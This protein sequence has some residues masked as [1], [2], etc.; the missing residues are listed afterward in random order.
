MKAVKNISDSSKWNTLTKISFR[1][2]VIFFFLHIFPFPLY[3]IGTILGIE[4]MFSFY[5]DWFQELALW[6]GKNILGI[7]YEMPTGR[8]G[9]GDTTTNY[10]QEFV[11]LLLSSIITIIWS[12]VDLK[13][14]NYNKLLLYFTTFLRYYVAAV[15]FSYGFSK[16]FTLQ[17]S[18]L[19]NVDLV[20][21]FGNQ[22]PMGLMWNFMEYSDTYTRFSGYA[23]VIAGLLLLFR[24]TTL[25]GALT[26]VAVMFNVFM[27]NMSYD[28]PVKLFSGLLTLMGLFLLIPDGKR[29]LNFLVFNK[30][31]REKEII[32]YSRKKNVK[33]A[34][35]ISKICFICFLIYT[36]IDRS[37]ERQ[38]KWGKNAPKS[39]I[40]GIYEVQKFI[41]NQDTIPPLT[42]DSI[43]WK[44]LII[45]KRFSNIQTMDEN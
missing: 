1:F 45:D 19:R 36:N 3:Y 34:I 2:F 37:I 30:P 23:E 38:N 15:M 7:T 12:I 4:N 16:V 24:K 9:S 43:R 41:K 13:R 42:T 25:L 10:V 22:S 32:T 28:I 39:A 20:K 18:E 33:T 26:T 6:T 27:M 5:F 40:Y 14:R 29:I 8:N 21:T 31:V 11:I 35:I 44:R 17:F